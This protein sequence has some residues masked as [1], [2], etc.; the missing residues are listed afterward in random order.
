MLRWV[1][2]GV[3]ADLSVQLISGVGTEHLFVCVERDLVKECP[4]PGVIECPDVQILLFTAFP[5]DQSMRHAVS[6]ALKTSPRLSL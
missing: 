3:V 5:D 2:V 4:D 6:L 1:L